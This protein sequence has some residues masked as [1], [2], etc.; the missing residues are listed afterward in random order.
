MSRSARRAQSEGLA[1]PAAAGEDTG[2]G[3][4]LDMASQAQ[5]QREGAGP[6]WP[7]WERGPRGR[8]FL[9]GCAHARRWP[10]ADLS[11]PGRIDA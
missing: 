3:A 10:G 1:R 9:R 11:A 6:A 7:G 4:V 2:P 8:P 5:R